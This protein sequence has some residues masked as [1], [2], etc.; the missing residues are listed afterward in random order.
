M[1]VYLD[2][3]ISDVTVVDGDLPL[4]DAQI[5][6]LVRLVLRRLEE[7]QRAARQTEAATTLRRDSEPPLPFGE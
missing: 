6:R 4:N 1:P 3:M 5:E 2:E 7:T